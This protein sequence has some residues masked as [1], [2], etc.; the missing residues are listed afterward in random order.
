MTT[1]TIAKSTL[2]ARETASLIE[3]GKTLLVAGEEELL[4]ELPRGNWVG[5]TTPYMMGDQGGACQH[6]M[7]QVTELPEFVRPAEIRFYV[8]ADL[9]KIPAGYR[10][11]GFSYI[12]V[13][14]FSSTH[15]HFAEECFSWPGIF[16]RPLVGWV[17][18]VDLKDQGKITPK[19]INGVTGEVSDNA[20][21]VMHAELPANLYANINI[22]NLFRQGSGDTLTFLE[23]GFEAAD[24]QINGVTHNLAE[25]LTE[26]QIDPRLPLVADFSGAMI[27]VSLQAVDPAVNKVRFYAPVFAGVDYKFAT[28]AGDYEAEFRKCLGS[29]DIEPVFSCNCILNY[30]YGHLE[31]KQTGKMKGPITFGEIGYILLNQTLV[32]LT[33]DE[34]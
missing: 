14:A 26:K 10:E 31:G 20:A 16:D 2:S 18:G 34:K 3:T 19:V 29:A 23:G 24:C 15:R 9:N 11:N 32:Y 17:A 22:V 6:N 1:N 30:I 21:V 33:F 27:N 8:A 13:P 12:V 5:G 7:L 4:R 28:P 25:Y